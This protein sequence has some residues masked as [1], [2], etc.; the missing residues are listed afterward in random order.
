[1]S[2]SAESEPQR[3]PENGV[4]IYLQSGQ[5]IAAVELDHGETVHSEPWITD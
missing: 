2:T 5:A 1:M 3:T 4:T